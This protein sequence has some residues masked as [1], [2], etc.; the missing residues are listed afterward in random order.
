MKVVVR[1]SMRRFRPRKR[2]R[3]VPAE[4]SWNHRDFAHEVDKSRAGGPGG[5]SDAELLH[6]CRG[7][8]GF[9]THFWA[10]AQP[11]FVELWKRIEE[12]RISYIH[13]KTEACRLIGCS[14]RWAEKIVAGTAKSSNSSKTNKEKAEFKGASQTPER[15]KQEYFDD[16]TGYAEKQLQPLVARGEWK[17]YS[18]ICMLLKKHFADERKL[19]HVDDLN[20][21]NRTPRSREQ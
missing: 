21:D 11:F 17:R 6:F 4:R 15:S 2:S 3:V 12:G 5:L 13:T 9:Y 1:T 8:D 16:I 19:A 20:G 7:A 10:D 18:N 14:L